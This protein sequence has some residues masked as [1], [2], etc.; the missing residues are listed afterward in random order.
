MDASVPGVSTSADA[1]L[2]PGG[3]SDDYNY[4]S[5]VGF[6]EYEDND[7]DDR[8]KE[9]TPFAERSKIDRTIHKFNDDHDNQFRPDSPVV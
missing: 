2:P 9:R 6:L 4:P 5:Q 1:F 7:E 3:T 8:G